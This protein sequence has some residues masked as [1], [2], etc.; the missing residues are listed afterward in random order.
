V[1]LALTVYH[2]ANTRHGAT[3][4]EFPL[5]EFP[6]ATVEVEDGDDFLGALRAGVKQTD[7]PDARDPVFKDTLWYCFADPTHAETP[8]TWGPAGRGYYWG[9]AA[10]GTLRA[11]SWWT[12]DFTVG[13]VRRAGLAGYLEGRWDHVVVMDPH[14]LGGAGDMTAAVQIFL[15]FLS[16]VGV[17]LGTTIAVA[18]LAV[19]WRRVRRA[20]HD[21][22]ARRLV[23]G[24]QRQGLDGPWVLRQWV[25]SQSTWDASDFAKRLS[26]TKEQAEAMLEAAG[27]EYSDRIL[28]WTVGTSKRSARRRE[29][30]EASGD[31]A[32]QRRGRPP[33]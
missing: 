10:D 15:D 20:K 1:P 6:S 28:K 23:A 25:D 26:L 2:R 22:R 27:F 18:P 31:L 3:D 17:E 13:D 16:Q 29:Q 14:G 12:V 7:P 32:W 11:A 5:A 19:L 4:E 33:G 8:K 9:V 24:W 21:H 30:W